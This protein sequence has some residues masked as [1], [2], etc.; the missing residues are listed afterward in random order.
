MGLLW[1]R[2]G[3][4]WYQLRHL[5]T[6]RE[7]Q[8]VDCVLQKCLGGKSGPGR[9]LFYPHN[10]YCSEHILEKRLWDIIMFELVE[11]P[12]FCKLFLM[13]CIFR[14]NPAPRGAWRKCIIPGLLLAEVEKKLIQELLTKRQT[15]GNWFFSLPLFSFRGRKKF[16]SIFLFFRERSRI[17]LKPSELH[18][19]QCVVLQVQSF[20]LHSYHAQ[21]IM[22]ISF[23]SLLNLFG[24]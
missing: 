22:V 10:H 23:T 15:K 19:L 4:I 12:K 20:T 6:K 21:P 5:H 13:M 16:R 1:K 18:D 3:T 2:A 11:S 7:S 9:M 14:E 17:I 24:T 8:T